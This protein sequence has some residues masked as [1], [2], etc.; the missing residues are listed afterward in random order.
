VNP[1]ERLSR[2]I[3]VGAKILRFLEKS[4]APLVDLLIRLGI[5]Q[6]FF[7]SA[8]LKL[9]NWENA[10]YLSAHEYP[11]AWMD[12]VS[13]AWLGI[14]VELAGSVLLAAGLA[15][16][17]AAL[18]LGAL[19]LVIQFNYL[20]LDV[21][22]FWAALAAWYV[23]RG[24]GPISLDR[25][26]APGLAD[27]AV[28]F[29][30]RAMAL[31]A[32]LSRRG[33]PLL[34]LA[35][36]LWLAAALLASG[37]AGGGMGLLVPVHSAAGF[38]AWGLLGLLLVPGLATRVAALALIGCAGG[39]GLA[40]GG[41]EDLGYWGAALA[42]LSLHGARPLSL[43]ALMAKALAGRFPQLQGKPAF[44]LEGLPR[45][46]IVGAGFG[47][48]ACAARLADARVAITL[49]DR[50]NY[51]LFQPLLYQVATT[52]LSPADI[53]TP[54]RGLFREHFNI[55]VLLGEVTGV[56]RGRQEVLA[57]GNRVPYDYLVIATGAA[58]SYFGRDEWGAFA[59]GLKRVEDATEVRRRL[60][61]AFEG[62]EA[63]ADPREREALL[64]FLIVGGGPTGVE[65]AGAIAE[66]A[67][68]GMEKEYRSFDP[69]AARILLVQAGPRL[70]PTFPESLSQETRRC[71][72]KLGVEVL[73][74]SRV[75]AID[76]AGVTVGGTRIPARTVLWAAGVVASPAARW[77]GAE[78]DNAGRVKVG[79]DLS[80]PGLPKVFVIGDT[81]ASDA[82]N[83]QPV[84]GLAPAA[85]QEGLYVA[86]LI[87]AR[88]EGR[89]AP[90]PFV[91]RH[92]GSLATIGR[93]S[94]VVDFGFL[95]LSGAP[96]WWLWG[97]VHIAFLIGLRNRLSVMLDWFWSYLTF[98]SGVRL[99]TGGAPAP[100]TESSAAAPPLR[101][102]AG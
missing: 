48:L 34:Q 2:M 47:G 68:F 16:R 28:P 7:V 43:D 5:A 88:L 58:H 62:A 79:P 26:M 10:L 92:L 19:A 22:L 71:L 42:L 23:V 78:A 101:T 90:G 83:G 102:A 12:P 9:A 55:R 31:A 49:I 15:T 44:S 3:T 85:K 17:A 77:L 100:A 21:H 72:E 59:P 18:G 70:L 35:L 73:I 56:D 81:A 67:R 51:H 1:S 54:I 84:P 6:V 80:V 11:V 33:T 82:W 98:R 86:K 65:L 66:L 32:A 99:I 27:S 14:T 8:V 46:V 38:G 37:L 63:C 60:L 94:A 64:T 76:D 53:A 30:A 45:V 20:A 52:A 75:E 97:A 96:A 93:K 91:Y 95:K 4:A 29:A 25:L 36:R 41:L 69:A 87:R 24:A 61:S 89:P 13:A 39:L 74:N 40:G 50:H 57:A